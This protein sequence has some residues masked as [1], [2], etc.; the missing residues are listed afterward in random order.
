MKAAAW[1][2]RAD[3]GSPVTP[4]PSAAHAVPTPPSRYGASSAKAGL[5]GYR[6]S[7]TSRA[8]GTYCRHFT[9]GTRN[10]AP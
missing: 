6:R 3:A 5:S 10:R 1:I 7:R 2:S 4:V 8:T 9:G